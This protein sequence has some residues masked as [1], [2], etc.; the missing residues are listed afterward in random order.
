MPDGLSG[1]TTLE[2]VHWQGNL[3][4]YSSFAVTTLVHWEVFQ[5][6]LQTEHKDLREGCQLLKCCLKKF[7]GLR[8]R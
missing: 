8:R 6:S 2:L 1:V 5:L 7:H 3:E 4:N